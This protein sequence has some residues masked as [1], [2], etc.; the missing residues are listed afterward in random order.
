M[1]YEIIL[2]PTLLEREIL[3]LLEA[4]GQENE[5]GRCRRYCPFWAGVQNDEGHLIALG[6]LVT[7]GLTHGYISEL[8]VHPH[9]QDQTVQEELYEFLLSIAKRSGTNIV[10]IDPEQNS[11]HGFVQSHSR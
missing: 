6:Y 8:L 2:N 3:D 9:Y 4:T 10:D 11:T 1:R 5:N 7:M